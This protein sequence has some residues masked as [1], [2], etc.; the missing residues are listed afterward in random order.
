MMKTR[1]EWIKRVGI[2]GLVGAPL[3][4]WG[5][6]PQAAPAPVSSRPAPNVLFIAV[7]DLNDWTGRMGGNRQAI[8]PH[9]DRF[10][11]QSILFGNAHTPMAV[12]VASRNSLLSGR[13][14]SSTGWYATGESAKAMQE[15][16]R[17]VMQDR[18]ML[19]AYFKKNGY[20]TCCAGKIFHS[21]ATDYPFLLNELWDDVL[22]SYESQVTGKFLERGG[23]YGGLVFYPFPKAGS[24]LKNHYGKELGGGH[25]LCGGPLDPEDIPGGKMYD[26]LIADYAVKELGKKQDK[27]FFLAVGFV[28]PHMPY[29]A[30]RKY[31][32]M[33]D[34]EKIEIP[35]VPDDEM[36]DIPV[37]GKAIAYGTAKMGD[38]QAVLGIT[39]YWRDMVHA[40]LACTTLADDQIGRVLQALD[41]SPYAS[42]TVVVLFS[43]HGQH[44]G[45]KKHWRKMSLWEESTRLPLAIRLPGNRNNGQV[46]NRP[47]SLLD[48][49][50]TLVDVCRLPAVNGL[51]G[52][53]LV[54]L[55]DQPAREW[56]YPVLSNWMYKNYSVRSERYRY[57][58][59]RDGSEELYDHQV[60]PNEH[61][62]QAGNPEFRDII[63][64][65]KKWIPASP[66]LPVGSATWKGDS[67]TKQVELWRGK[68]GIPAWLE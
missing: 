1:N 39:N 3:F 24:Q 58:Q 57:I 51:E 61:I 31:F 65:H 54:P 36:K 26:E 21:G 12:C 52:R 19:P 29:T 35:V 45:E 32:E 27:P 25:S 66:A 43:D 18:V 37:I 8:T 22:P 7:D 44:L 5:A 50:P 68:D 40:Y 48:L 28:R 49:Y 16:Y 30:P 33:Y 53:S 42:N 34:K 64:Q 4:G 10:E 62:N 67:L 60:D 47:V 46:C 14:P 9:M 20:H 55:L 56:P 11:N 38:H 6:A 13:H 2:A 23:G 17:T 63:E 59:Y 15:S 41:A